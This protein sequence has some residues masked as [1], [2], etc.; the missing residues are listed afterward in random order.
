MSA[1]FSYNVAPLQGENNGGAGGGGGEPVGGGLPLGTIVLSA[2]AGSSDP[3]WLVCDSTEYRIDTNNFQLFNVIGWRYS[4][5][6][7]VETQYFGT[8]TYGTGTPNEIT[9]NTA[10]PILNQIISVGSFIKPYTFIATT[11]ANINGSI[12]RI[13]SCPA[14]NTNTT[15]VYTGVFVPP[16]TGTGTGNASANQLVSRWS[17][18]VPD[19]T[20]RVPLGFNATYPRATTGGSATTTL[21]ADNLPQHRHGTPVPG[22]SSATAGGG[23]RAG[24]FNVD[25]GTRTW[26]NQTYLENGSTLA[27]NSAFS[28]LPPYLAVNYIIKSVA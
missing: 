16:I 22:T 26:A 3:D 21:T 28:N 4:P 18:N 19:L 6:T 14:L 12:I 8:Y 23:L 9:F 10:T 17:Y 25:D 2:L 20:G 15:G 7:A 24:T 5:N 11:G 27:T 13:T 1:R